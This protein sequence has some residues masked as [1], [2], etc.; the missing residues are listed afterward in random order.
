MKHFL[1]A[2]FIPMTLSAENMQQLTEQLGKTVLY[3]DI[4]ISSDGKNVACLH[5]NYGVSLY[6]EFPNLFHLELRKALTDTFLAFDSHNSC[7]VISEF[8]IDGLTRFSGQ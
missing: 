6:S 3:G 5:E 8:F 2:F 1:L 7:G 4:A